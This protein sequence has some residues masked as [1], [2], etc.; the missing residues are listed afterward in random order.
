M[1]HVTKHM[2]NFLCKLSRHTHK[3]THTLTLMF[4]FS[5]PPMVW[6][7][8]AGIMFLDL[9]RN[10]PFTE[11]RQN[12]KKHLSSHQQLPIIN[13]SSQGNPN[14]FEA[15][16]LHYGLFYLLLADSLHIYALDLVSL[17]SGTSAAAV[18]SCFYKA[19]VGW[20]CL[21]VSDVCR[22]RRSVAHT[23]LCV[24]ILFPRSVLF[25][26][27]PTAGVWIKSGKSSAHIWA[28]LLCCV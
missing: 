21:S 10:T 22:E 12:L 17:S 7:S 14:N 16:F 23:S 28:I 4:P 3:H 18:G 27:G 25:K 9:H 20:K 13:L 1:S 19:P 15:L 26:L 5:K 24:R 11:L 6:A 2:S 8:A